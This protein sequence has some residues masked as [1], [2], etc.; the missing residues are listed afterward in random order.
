MTDEEATA[1]KRGKWRDGANQHRGGANEALG[2]YRGSSESWFVD[3]AK[4]A[5]P[6][7]TI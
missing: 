5:H 7:E 4:S 2:D 3:V 6:A 1:D